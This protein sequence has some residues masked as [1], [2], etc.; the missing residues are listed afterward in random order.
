MTWTC[1][2][3][4]RASSYLP[5]CGFN[6]IEPVVGREDQR[7]P[8]P[9]HVTS[10]QSEPRTAIEIFACGATGPGPSRRPSYE[11]SSANSVDQPR[12]LD[13]LSSSEAGYFGS[14]GRGTCSW[15]MVVLAMR[16]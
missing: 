1:G 10:P 2:E 8:A 3:W 13:A 16:R 9:L 6:Q 12:S 7:L 15:L 11:Q 5:P 14:P 4:I